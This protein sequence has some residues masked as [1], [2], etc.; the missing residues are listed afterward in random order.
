MSAKKDAIKSDLAAYKAAFDQTG[1]PWVIIG[2]VVLGYA[3]YKD[4]MDWD[5]D[6]DIVVPVELTNAIWQDLRT[7]LAMNGLIFSA[8]KVDFMYCYRRTECNMEFYHKDGN[9]YNCFPKST[10]GLKFV[11]KAM[12]YDEPQIVDFLGSKYPMPNH[13]EDFVSAHY[14]ADWKTNI[15]KDHAQYFTEKR[16]GRDQSLWLTSRAGKQGDLWPKI[17]KLCDSMEIK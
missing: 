8:N 13:I 5:T 10:P 11:E 1:I 16:G 9:V 12:W 2:G 3:R 17:L 15:I 7:A 6:S 4:I 14:G